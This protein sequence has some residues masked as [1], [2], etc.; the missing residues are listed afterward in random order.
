[1]EALLA[2]QV[3]MRRHGW[4]FAGDDA[5]SVNPTPVVNKMRP[6]VLPIPFKGLRSKTTAKPVVA[7][8][9]VKPKL[10][11]VPFSAPVVPLLPNIVQPVATVQPVA[12]VGGVER[13]NLID[14]IVA[15]W[16]R[17]TSNLQEREEV[18]VDKSK[19]VE[20][21]VA[22]GAAAQALAVIISLGKTQ[23]L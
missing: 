3:N 14:A 23:Q 4:S 18:V 7:A 8:A 21:G 9:S 16:G 6:I 10:N 1:M 19:V 5:P 22:Y 15:A 20:T 2:Y 13:P 17:F 11:Q 12:S